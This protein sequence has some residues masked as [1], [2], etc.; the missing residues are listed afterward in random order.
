MKSFDVLVSISVYSQDQNWPSTNQETVIL[1][2]AEDTDIDDSD[3]VMAARP[4][5]GNGHQVLR[6]TGKY[7][8]VLLKFKLTLQHR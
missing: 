3:V 4:S 5:A 1:Q 2:E 6:R 8:R 7:F